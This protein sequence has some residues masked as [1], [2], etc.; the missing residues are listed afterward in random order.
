M[1]MSNGTYDPTW[2]PDTGATNHMTAHDTYHGT[3]QVTF[4]KKNTLSI[5]ATGN[6]NIHTPSSTFKLN[7]VLHV[8]RLTTNLLFVS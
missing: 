6:I 3:E 8:P 4:T 1:S 2:F 5:A 7:N